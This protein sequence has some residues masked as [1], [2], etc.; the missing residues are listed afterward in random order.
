MA[1]LQPDKR[2]DEGAKPP[3]APAAELWSRLRES[4]AGLNSIGQRKSDPAALAERL[5]RRAKAYRARA[6]AQERAETP[7]PLLA[8][9]KGSQ[10]YALL[11]EYVREVQPLEQ[12]HPV[13]KAPPF[14]P[15]VAPWRGSILALVDL[16][17]LFGVA[18]TGLADVHRCIVV[19]AAGRRVAIVARE[20]E[21]I[22]NVPARLIHPA[23]ELPGNIVPEWVLGVYDE[24]CLVL[25]IDQILQDPAL[26]AWRNEGV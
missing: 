15:G 6:A 4:M 21:E 12:F 2:R 3:E 8:F 19:E 17:R 9:S 11:L 22:H 10:R 20:V 16:G 24:D 1:R 14:L 7:V 23:P 18:E 5:A 13:P 25:R 26:T